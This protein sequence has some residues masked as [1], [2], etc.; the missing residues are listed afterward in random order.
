MTNQTSSHLIQ[1]F[2]EIFMIDTTH[3]AFMMG[4]AYLPTLIPQKSTKCGKIY[5]N[6]PYLDGMAILFTFPTTI[7]SQTTSAQA[8]STILLPTVLSK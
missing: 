8:L 6:I 4:M 1:D 5:G 3:V 7:P 2:L